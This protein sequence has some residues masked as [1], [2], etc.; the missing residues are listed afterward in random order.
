MY[1]E[2]KRI[3]PIDAL[4]G[5]IYNSEKVLQNRKCALFSPIKFNQ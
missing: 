1:Q 2:E 3:R 4:K 5:E